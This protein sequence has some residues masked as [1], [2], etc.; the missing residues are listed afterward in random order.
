MIQERLMSILSEQ[1]KN[2]G[3][4]LRLSS[5][6]RKQRTG[7]KMMKLLLQMNLCIYVLNSDRWTNAVAGKE[8]SGLY[9]G[10]FLYMF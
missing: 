8:N 2:G 10:S 5:L 4:P 1:K 7:Q 9:Y 3:K 6:K